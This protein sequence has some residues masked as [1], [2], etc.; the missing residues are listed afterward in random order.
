MSPYSTYTVWKYI[1]T[2]SS[3][4]SCAL[5][6]GSKLVIVKV[7]VC[8]LYKVTILQLL[9][10]FSDWEYTMTRKTTLSTLVVVAVIVLEFHL[11]SQLLVDHEC[12]V[13]PEESS[14]SCPS[15]CYT[16]QE[17]ADNEGVV[18]NCSLGTPN[19]AYIFLSGTHELCDNISLNFLRTDSIYL[20][21]KALNS[22]RH[23]PNAEITCYKQDGG[24]LFQN[25]TNIAIT[26]LTFTDCGRWYDFIVRGGQATL[27]FHNVTNVTIADVAVRKSAG[28]GV[29]ALCAMGDVEVVDSVFAFNSGTVNY[30]GGNAGFRYENCT[31]TNTL[32]TIRSSHFLYGYA[33]HN[34]PLASGLCVFVWTSGVNVEIDNITAIG[35]VAVNESTGGNVALFLRNRTNIITNWIVVKN[36]YI[37]N[38]SAY[39]GAGMYVSIT[40]TPV[41]DA[42]SHIH[43]VA[44]THHSVF[45]P[46]LT[47]EIITVTNTVHQ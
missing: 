19:T 2:A 15:P 23:V 9:Q 47:P 5:D 25:T 6:P 20:V 11:S 4:L 41:Y 42:A 24:F 32:L 35:N 1:A 31:D 7:Y 33:E 3:I 43:D 45:S 37:A 10:S 17:Y 40:D 27:G 16:L 13:K 36:S 46:V 38:G 22:T 12:Y 8:W 29:Y 44:V 28:Y 21:G 26:N 34:N 39:T 18:K 14:V 30:D